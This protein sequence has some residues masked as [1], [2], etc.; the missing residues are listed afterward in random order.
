[1]C[2]RVWLVSMC[3]RSH[4]NLRQNELLSSCEQHGKLSF[5]SQSVC[6]CVGDR[7]GCSVSLRLRVCVGTAGGS[8]RRWAAWKMAQCDFALWYAII[9]WH[10]RGTSGCV[11]Q[12]LSRREVRCVYCGIWSMITGFQ[13]V[14]WHVRCMLCLRFYLILFYFFNLIF[15]FILYIL[16]TEK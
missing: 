3:R 4:R 6:V 14:L 16:L 7:C 13:N 12:P 15:N 1:M 11:S 5:S 2:V 9:W 8:E 10:S